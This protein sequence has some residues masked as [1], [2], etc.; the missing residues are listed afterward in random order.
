MK[1]IARFALYALIIALAVAC[2]A[3]P[4]RTVNQQLY[5]YLVVNT[6]GEI[7]VAKGAALTDLI[8]PDDVYID[9]KNTATVF[10]GFQDEAD[11]VNLKSVTIGSGITDI[12][13]NAFKEAES[14]ESVT[15]EKGSELEM[16]GSSAFQNTGL[17]SVVLPDTPVIIGEN[18]FTGNEALESVDL[19]G[20]KEVG[21]GAFSGNASLTNVDFG[22]VSTIGDEAFMNT[23]LYDVKL[24]ETPVIIGENAFN[25]NENLQSVDLGGTTEVGNGAFGGNASLS[26]VDFGSVSVIGDDAFKNTGLTE[27][28]LPPFQS[29]LR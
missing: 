4:V 29:G 16:I 24:P 7:R 15:F 13:A 5:P 12:G 21:K 19:G 9:G 28:V 6:S 26:S 18:A 22:S 23:G 1:R 27:V 25:G 8:I 3:D 14:L 11:K 20:T 10:V 2:A 17:V